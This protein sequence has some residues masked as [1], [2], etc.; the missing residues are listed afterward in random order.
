M[1]NK[2]EL[3]N[4]HLEYF[5]TSSAG[6]VNEIRYA[7]ALVRGQTAS[8]VKSWILFLNG[9]SEWIEKY[10][11]IARDF[12][13]GPDVGFL[14]L[15]H[16]GQGAST[17]VRGHIDS[18]DTYV[19]DIKKIVAK[20]ID[21]K[22]Y[23]LVAHSMGCLIG[24]YALGKN[25]LKPQKA[26]FLSPFFGITDDPL[27]AKLAT[28]V[29]ATIMALRLGSKR[30]MGGAFEKHPFPGNRLTHDPVKYQL[31]K[32]SPYKLPPPTFAWIAATF[33]A[34]EFVAKPES[35]K[36]ITCPVLVLA[37]SDERCVNP[38]A[39]DRWVQ[40]AAKVS[41]ALIFYVRIQKARHELLSEVPEVYEAAL[42]QIK[43]FI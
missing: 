21:A 28:Y 14:F 16:R 1:T 23:I 31:S 36:N 22:S 15:D 33:A 9:R 43:N 25:I 11:Y 7:T 24:A 5:W 8:S 35:I 10:T 27:P 4:F 19:D 39:I 17:G 20:I 34:Q 13:L 2:K 30:A 18:Y 29:T 42:L 3:G 38:R 26:V 37:S 32:D 12:E 6:D 41:P 40:S